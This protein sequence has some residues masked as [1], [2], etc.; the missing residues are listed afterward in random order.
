M[1]ERGYSFAVTAHAFHNIGATM[2]LILLKNT[3]SKN[4]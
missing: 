3:S 4:G 2:G 1:R